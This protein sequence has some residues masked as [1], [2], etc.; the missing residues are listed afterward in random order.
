[1][2]GTLIVSLDFELFWGMLD[3]CALEDYRSNVL[4]GRE[5]IPKL[6]KLFEKYNIHATWAAVGF[7]FA[8]NKQELS[9][10]F[11]EAALQPGYTDPA[12]SPYPWFARLG[13]NEEEEPCFYAPS[14]IRQIAETPG[15]EIGSHTF[16]HYYCQEN[17]QTAQQFAADLRAAKKIAA[18]KGY[19]VK[20][21]VLP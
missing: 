18:A 19:D 2:P 8:E 21:L 12:V 3:K 15:Q 7:L 20:S 5:A 16:C 11:P 14:L 6:L 13:E 4:G 1:M 10:F 17:G 9:A